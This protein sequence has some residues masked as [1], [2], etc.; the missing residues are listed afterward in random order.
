M[1]E[2][3]HI[4]GALLK[5]ITQARALSD[6]YSQEVSRYYQ[7]NEQLNLFPI[8]RTEVDNVQLHL[9]FVINQ[10]E[11]YK[12]LS[13]QHIDIV[14]S[15]FTNYAIR[16]ANHW[17][18]F[19]N[20]TTIGVMQNFFADIPADQRSVTLPEVERVCRHFLH[21]N[22]Y[23]IIEYMVYKRP[24]FNRY[25]VTADGVS[26]DPYHKLASYLYMMIRQ[27]IKDKVEQHLG[28][29]AW[30]NN[31]DVVATD[32]AYEGHTDIQAKVHTVR[33]ILIEMEG[34]IDYHFEELSSQTIWVTM[35]GDKLKTLP[36]EAASSVKIGAVINNYVWSETVAEDGTVNQVLIRE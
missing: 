11:Q 23:I 5:D 3:H 19:L 30:V 31:H 34:D 17:H 18:S 6:R 7:G 35:E 36:S 33:A 1:A 9:K 32:I 14:K 21:N 16:I 10:A 25:G 4:I 8:P 15:V 12:Y 20:E 28:T 24:L 2:F 27:L 13:N 26:N 29:E 22:L